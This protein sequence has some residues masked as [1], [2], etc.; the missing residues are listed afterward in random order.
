MKSEKQ[1]FADIDR[2]TCYCLEEKQCKEGKCKFFKT[3]EQ[4]RR[5]YFNTYSRETAGNLD[6]RIDKY[7]R[8]L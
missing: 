3:R 1:C 7:F 6:V 4:A 8:S 2:N 5:D